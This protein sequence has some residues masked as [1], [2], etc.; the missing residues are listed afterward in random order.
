MRKVGRGDE[1]G[2][3]NNVS[4]RRVRGGQLGNP[5]TEKLPITPVR[6]KGILPRVQPGSTTALN[7]LPNSFGTPITFSRKGE[8]RE[9]VGSLT[10]QWL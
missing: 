6:K 8:A 10:I 3:V 4:G 1:G 2:V 5:G 7:D 9:E